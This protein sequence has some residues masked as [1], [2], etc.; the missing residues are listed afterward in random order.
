VYFF[1]RAGM[2]QTS[3]Y[4]KAYLR[5]KA[6]REKAEA[7]LESRARELFESNESLRAALEQ[8][9]KQ[10]SSLVQQEKLASIGLLAAGIAHEINNPV[11][12]VKSNL[13]SLLG[14]I[15]ALT[16]PLNSY[17]KIAE[18]LSSQPMSEEMKL[19]LK[20]INLLLETEDIKYIAS[21]SI[22]S[23]QEGLIGIK[24]VEDIVRNLKDYSRAESDQRSL[25]DV[26]AVIDD[27]LKLI[28]NELKYKCEITKE[29]GEIPLI[30]GSPGQLSQIFINIAMN[31]AQA[32]ESRGTLSI[33]TLCD[34]AHIYVFFTDDGPG[35]EEDI[36]SKLFDP[37]FTT[38]DIGG[39]TGLGLYVSYGLAKKH[40]GKIEVANNQGKGATFTV[41][42][43]INI[44]ENRY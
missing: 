38:K 18:E 11:G 3:N 20:S 6:A 10:K 44:R 27:A 13:Q 19:Q 34:S 36:Q 32:I 4:Y 31:A 21:D 24:R 5:Q 2:S 41:T 8:L 42:L 40:R 33:G 1:D 16:K 43:P 26:N 23:I 7:L 37:F 35:I 14:Y 15:K 30:Y 9:Q 39:G 29:F 12:F 17:L 22:D 28:W 25:I